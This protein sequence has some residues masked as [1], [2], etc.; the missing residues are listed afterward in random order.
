M[1]TSKTQDG[2]P[3]NIPKSFNGYDVLKY[4]GCGSTCAVILVEDEKT[5]QKYSAK[6]MS[7]KDIEA[8]NL[9]ESTMLEIKVLKELDHPHIIKVYDSFE[10]KSANDEY[11]VIIMEYCENGDLL[12]YATSSGFKSE[13]QKKKII[14]EF[15]E[16]IKYLHKKGI[17][18]GDIKSENVLLDSKFSPKLCDFGFCR[19][20]KVAG[21]EAKKGT[22][23]YAAPELFVR[24]EFDTIKTDIW[25]IG[26]TLYSLFE[27]QFPFKDGNQNFIIKQILSGRLSISKSLDFKVRQI[28]QDCTQ[29]MAA[30]RPTIDDIMSSDYFRDVQFDS[31]LNQHFS[32]KQS[33]IE[34]KP[35]CNF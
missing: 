24:G 3:I 30:S 18:H 1:F 32:P 9:V 6:V 31:K 20:K 25:A 26:I 4:L 5:K 13:K 35:K 11:Y 17:S 19:T 27:L 14:Y 7:K 21:D 10:I 2:Y 23:Y 12:S 34:W 33:V 28:V 8:R 15:L 29:M 22:F 16:A